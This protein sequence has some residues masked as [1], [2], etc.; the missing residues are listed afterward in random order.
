[1]RDALDSRFVQRTVYLDPKGTS[2]VPTTITN[3][4]A[5]SAIIGVVVVITTG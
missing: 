1:L 5:I 3:P 2:V 4:T